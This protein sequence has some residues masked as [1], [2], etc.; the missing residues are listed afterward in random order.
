MKQQQSGPEYLQD[1]PYAY[2]DTN[3]TEGP[4]AAGDSSTVSPNLQQY[5]NKNAPFSSRFTNENWLKF[6][7]PSKGSCLTGSNHT[8]YI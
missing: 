6:P 1:I 3:E 8:G 5:Q 7:L 2:Y 4:A